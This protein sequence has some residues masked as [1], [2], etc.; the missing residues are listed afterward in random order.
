MGKTRLSRRLDRD[1]IQ[2][3]VIR[4]HGQGFTLEF[5]AADNGITVHQ[6]RGIIS[7]IG[8]QDSDEAGVHFRTVPAYRCKKCAKRLGVEFPPA[9]TVNPCVLCLAEV[10]K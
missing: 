4:Q 9:I 6:V 2:R 5:M 8:R 1:V 3:K 7:R 10:G